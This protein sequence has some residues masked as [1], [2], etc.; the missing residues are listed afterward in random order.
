MKINQKLKAL[1]SP[2]VLKAISLGLLLLLCLGCTLLS[3]SAVALGG[4][5]SG[6]SAQ[7]NT[8][9][10]IMDRFDMAVT[11]QFS[12]SMEGILSIDKVYWL[13]DEDVVAPKP[14]PALYGQTNNPNDIL[15]VLEEAKELLDGQ[16]VLFST[17]KNFIPNVP[18]R[19]YLDDTILVIVWQEE[20]QGS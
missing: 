11:N 8:N 16:E 4:K 15:T 19:Y 14:N 3:L 10:A 9:M 6:Q 5:S 18:I 13:R 12:A 1:R 2:A 17:D 7:T 20:Y